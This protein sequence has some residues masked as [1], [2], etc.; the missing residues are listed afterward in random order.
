LYSTLDGATV[1]LITAVRGEPTT[2]SPAICT[3]SRVGPW[4]D[5]G[6]VRARL[7]TTARS[8][9]AKL[10]PIRLIIAP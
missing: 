10:H 7:A 9:V 6:D 5:A 8:P 4:A 1:P 3:P 2:V